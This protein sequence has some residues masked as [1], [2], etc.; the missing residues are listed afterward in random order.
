MS[1][2]SK[3]VISR[4]AK[5]T[6]NKDTESKETTVYGTIKERNGSMY[7]LLDGAEV[8][9]PVTTTVEFKD[10]D[11]VSVLL[12][13]HTATVTGNISSPA[14]NESVSDLEQTVKDQAVVIDNNQVHR[15]TT[16]PKSPVPGTTIWLDF[17]VDPPL[18]KR[19]TIDKKWEVVGTDKVQTSYIA[20]R[21]NRIDIRTGGS[22]V[23]DTGASV[24]IKSGGTFTVEAEN[25]SI[26]EEGVIS[27]KKA[28]LEDATISGTLFASGYPVLHTGNVII[29]SA[30]PANPN[31]GT[32][33]INP[34]SNIQ[35]T[36]IIPAGNG[37][38]EEL[39]GRTRVGYFQ[40]D[41]VKA[42]SGTYTYTVKIPIYSEQQA[43]QIYYVRAVL[44]SE[45]SAVYCPIQTYISSGLIWYEQKFTRDYWLGNEG[46]LIVF[47]EISYDIDFS[48]LIDKDLGVFWRMLGYQSELTMICTPDN[49]TGWQNAEV[50]YFAG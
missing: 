42:P 30:Q 9:T 10:G 5:L 50:K 21:N 29:S 40:G 31:L 16:A 28:S 13:N 25:L 35:L 44:T 39:S 4:F 14:R 45:G 48:N 7:V 12:K 46:S 32:V 33:W 20:I 43:G 23:I 38:R 11:R 26:N 37:G 1:A 49:V 22:L 3:N 24:S 8:L 47:I 19:Y 17:S 2:L 18:L 36:H 27:A 6:A 34:N 41:V 15:G